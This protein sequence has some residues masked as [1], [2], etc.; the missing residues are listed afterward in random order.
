MKDNSKTVF[1]KAGESL[2][3]IQD[4]SDKVIMTDMAFSKHFKTKI[5]KS[6]PFIMKDIS[7]RE[8]LVAKE[9]KLKTPDSPLNW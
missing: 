5:D 3:T 4:S 8:N 7:H 6:S 2:R 9:S 1:L